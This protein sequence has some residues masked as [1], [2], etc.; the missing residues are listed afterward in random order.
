MKLSVNSDRK[1]K[2]LTPVFHPYALVT[3]SP[4]SLGAINHD[5]SCADQTMTW[6]ANQLAA[7]SFRYDRLS[8]FSSFRLLSCTPPPP[9]LQAVFTDPWAWS[10]HHPI[11]SSAPPGLDSS[12]GGGGGEI[13]LVAD[14]GSRP[15]TT[16]L[17]VE[18]K[19]QR[20]WD[21]T[22]AHHM[23]TINM[24]LSSSNWSFP[25]WTGWLILYLTF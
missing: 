14:R 23:L 19:R 2:P 9:H 8:T 21:F 17:P 11:S 18:S 15:S 25:D 16:N 3:Y 13:Y 24:I 10:T 7:V 12:G 6:R 20:L 4:S 5:S 22:I 1:T